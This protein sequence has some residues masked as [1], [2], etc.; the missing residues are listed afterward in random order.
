MKVKVFFLFI[1]T[2]SSCKYFENQD[3][4]EVVA[5]VNNHYLYKNEID[6]L[7]LPGTPLEDSILIVKNYIDR[8]AQRKLLISAAEI[9]LSVEKQQE[10]QK[11]INQY[12]DDLLTKAYLEE[13]V[14]QSIDTIVSIDELK[15]YYKQN[16]DNFKTTGVLVRLRYIYLSKDHEQ[17][18]IIKKNFGES[19]QKNKKFWERYQM[20]FKSSAL[21]DSVWVEMNQIYRKLPFITPD[22]RDEYIKPGYSFEKTDSLDLYLVKIRDV[23]EKN[24][25]SPFEY[26]KPTLKEVIL[27]AR[28]LELIK[29]IEKDI[30]NDAIKN[31]KYEV[32]E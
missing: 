26:L 28:K 21:N 4:R 18:N 7:I 6:D 19:V 24:E 22:N 5:R 16:K 25:I 3:Y 30:T 11:L 10:F 12:R 31:K 2:L 32:F 8:W 14:K 20:Q 27:N 1:I 15:N 9:N 23:I 17:L 13:I 29:K